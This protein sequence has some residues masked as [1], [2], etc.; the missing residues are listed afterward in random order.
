M[1]QLLCQLSGNV[2]FINFNHNLPLIIQN[3]VIGKTAG[4]V[5]SLVHWGTKGADIRWM[6]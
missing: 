1:D 5:V 3:R 2:V 6:T 4:P